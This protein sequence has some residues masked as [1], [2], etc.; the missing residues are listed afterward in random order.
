MCPFIFLH[1]LIYSFLHF[2]I[3][4]FIVTF[5]GEGWGG[6]GRACFLLGMRSLLA[7]LKNAVRHK[8]SLAKGEGL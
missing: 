8:S 1:L 4:S 2:F 5:V 6:G 3:Y 7:D